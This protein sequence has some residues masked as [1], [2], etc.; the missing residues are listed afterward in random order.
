M[1]TRTA[2]WSLATV[3]AALL[4]CK[5]APKKTA[6]STSLP[7]GAIPVASIPLTP[8]P[9]LAPL[10]S[11]AIPSSFADLA[12]R[13]DPAVVFV[14]TLQERGIQGRRRVIGDTATIHF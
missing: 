11:G 3:A 1:T 4:A 12:A 6:P 2:L 13:A 14:K 10:P 8:P 9:P 5:A 7:S